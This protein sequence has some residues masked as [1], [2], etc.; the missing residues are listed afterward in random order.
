MLPKGHRALSYNLWAGNRDPSDRV[1]GASAPGGPDLRAGVAGGGRGGA[2]PL[3]AR[4]PLAEVSKAMRL[5][6]SRTVLGKVV[7]VP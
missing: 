7:L 2:S 5:A 3:A 1:P 6:E 4:I